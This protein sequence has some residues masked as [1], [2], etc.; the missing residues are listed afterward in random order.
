MI[1]P[2][3]PSSSARIQ[4]KHKSRLIEVKKNHCRHWK[5]FIFSSCTIKTHHFNSD[6]YSLLQILLVPP[7]VQNWLNLW[8]YLVCLNIYFILS[9]HAFQ[10]VHESI[11]PP[12][13][14]ATILPIPTVHL[15]CLC[16]Y[17][18]QIITVFVSFLCTISIISLCP[19]SSSKTKW[20]KYSNCV[21]PLCMRHCL[22]VI[23]SNI[24]RPDCVISRNHEKS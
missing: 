20:N 23:V 13:L 9:C 17:Y 24:T 2:K 15:F 6:C 11:P 16:I 10:P 19:T 18:I 8:L 21:S 14:N 7:A 3:N 4:I 5:I 22:Y 1:K 12:P